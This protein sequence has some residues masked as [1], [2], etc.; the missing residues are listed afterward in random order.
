M[1]LQAGCYKTGK[2][3][4]SHLPESVQKNIIRIGLTLERKSLIIRLAMLPF[5]FGLGATIGRG[6]HAFP[7]VHTKD[8]IKAF[9]WIVNNYNESGIFNA[10]APENISNKDF[11]KTFARILNRPLFLMIPKFAIQLLLGKVSAMIIEAPQ[12]EPKKLNENGFQFDYP[13]IDTAL[14]EIIAQKNLPQ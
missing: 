3:P 8:V 1:A 9:L 11:S 14:S 10:V 13:T 5:K 12:V 4:L 6:N 7:F 2:M